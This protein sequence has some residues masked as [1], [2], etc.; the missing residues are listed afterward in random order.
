MKSEKF[1]PQPKIYVRQQ[2]VQD[3]LCCQ[4]ALPV[5]ALWRT[6]FVLWVTLTCVAF[7]FRPNRSQDKILCTTDRSY[8][9]TVVF[10]RILSTVILN[11]WE[12][13]PNGTKCVQCSQKLPKK[14]A[15]F[16]SSVYLLDRS[17]YRFWTIR[18]VWARY[19][20]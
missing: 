6:G 14:A 10:H 12:L 5:S 11:L 19:Y 4:F 9:L 13:C 2:N 7:G 8:T 3:D 18:S 16:P 20:Y 15:L 17:P 1:S